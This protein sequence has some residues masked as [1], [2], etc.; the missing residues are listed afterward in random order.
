MCFSFSA[1]LCFIHYL[2]F[3][4]MME[5]FHFPCTAEGKASQRV[6][7]DSGSPPKVTALASSSLEEAACFYGI[8]LLSRTLMLKP[9]TEKSSKYWK[10]VS[11]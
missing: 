11:H 2:D 1:F 5:S 8:P 4:Y 6:E 9:R 7:P 3:Y 10:R